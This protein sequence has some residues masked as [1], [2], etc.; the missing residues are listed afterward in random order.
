MSFLSTRTGKLL[1]SVFLVIALNTSV[2]AQTTLLVGD[3]AFSGYKCNDAVPDQF[4][5]VLLKNITLNTVIRFT[6]YG[7]HND[8]N[9]FSNAPSGILESEIVFT[10]TSALSAG[11]EIT[12]VGTT[13]TISGGPGSGTAVFSVGPQ[14]LVASNISLASNGDQIFAYQGTFAAPVFIAGIHMNVD[15]FVNPGDPPTTTAAAW[16]GLVPLGFRNNN[17]SALPP[18]LT[19]YTNANWFGTAG[20]GA[21]E[22]DNVRFVCGSTPVN[23]VPLAL[24]ALNS[25]NVPAN[26]IANNTNPSGFILP[27]GCNY[28]NI[29][30]SPPAFTLHP[31]NTTVCEA[32]NTSFTITATS[33]VSY[34]W[35]VDNGVGF[36]NIT[37]NATYSGAITTTLNITG[38]T[39]SMNGYI[40]RCVATNGFGS[41]NSNPATLTVTALPVNPTL[42]LK[43]PATGTVADGTPV[44]ATFNAGS[45]GSGCIDDFRYTT[46]GG[47]SY[48]P[49]TPGS[50]ISTTGLAAGTGFVFIEGRRAGCAT[51]SGSYVV[52]ASWVVTP[53]PPAATTLNAG[54]IG[55][56]GYNSTSA[57][58]EFSFVLLRNIGPGTVINFTDNG[59]LSTNVF[60]VGESTST[61]T[62]NAAYP[63][64]TEIKISGLTATLAAG[65]S[66][67]TVTGAALSLLSTGDQV[68]AY[69]GTAAAPTFISAIHMNVEV[70]STN[71]AWDGAVISGNASALPTGL[72]SGVNCIWIG[73]PGIFA[74]EHNNAKYGLC[75]LPAVLGSIVALRAALNNQ[76]NW[77]VDDNTPSLIVLPTGCPYFGIGAAPNIT[78]HPSPATVCELANTSFTI[79]ATGA[80]IYQWEVDPGTGFVS[81]VNNANYSG[82]TTATLNITAAPLSFNGYIYRCIA[83]NGSGSTTSNPATLTVTAL[84][85]SP[86][87]LTKT[88]ATKTVPD[89]TPVSA[90]FN[91]GSGGTG[92]SDDY[93]YTTD[94]GTTYLPYT[95]GSNI[96]TTG[97]AAGS[98]FV[99]IEGRRANCSAGCQGSYTVLAAWRVSPLPAAPTTLNAGD[100]AFS[101][102][103]STSIPNDE[104]SFVLLKNIGP[105]TVINF[106]D[107][108]WLSTNV[109]GVGESTAT[110]T[111]PAGGLPGGTEIKISALTATR[112]GGGP[113]G[114][115][116][117]AALSLLSTGDQVIA[118]RG[119]AA[120]PT[121]ISAIHM[122]VE[123]GSTNASWDGAVV[124]GNASAL[125]TGLT[126]GVNCIWI[127]LPGDFSSEHNNAKYGLC[128]LPAVSGSLVALR[129]ALNNQANWTVDDNTPPLFTLPT[130]CNYLSAACAVITVTNPAVTTGQQNTPFSQT[131]TASGGDAPYTFTTLSV[132]CRIDFIS[133]RCIKWNA[134]CNRYIPDCGNCNRCQRMYRNRTHL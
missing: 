34:Q 5:F 15:V 107:N 73:L 32:G 16:D 133:S 110:W 126:S 23:T 123:A 65:G 63:A 134:N 62:S 55:F 48:L 122:N 24:A 86:T 129:A 3:I 95:P 102:Y 57:T 124:S 97:L 14:F 47:V 85:I 27:T 41:T 106:T 43:T 88:P 113:A 51:C 7:W 69:R 22:R 112:S 71:A 127:G 105:G 37:D 74:S 56:T 60:G 84:P 38:A 64:G 9:T 91:A 26:W 12:I 118:Y 115:V 132:A 83:S 80:T 79:T 36:A 54:D 101:G 89:G 131:F 52:L 13:V 4:S 42:L 40:Y 33:A 53:L 114:T 90:T 1:L 103:T 20:V 81:V 2:K 116:T 77:T 92:C 44:S 98:G 96:S 128:S 45:G 8:V 18:A 39:N 130:G 93:R 49:Y 72:S 50:N 121:F 31:A 11:Q 59:W 82:A 19:T 125:P 100:I 46:N 67:G 68:L 104:F 30:S 94:G 35:Q 111:A 10:A 66:A 21:S 61:W 119:T 70:G 25:G 58:D 6:D 117:G 120:A 109:F 28:L 99:F 75:G 87:L 29:L 78:V 17:H 108:G 76:A